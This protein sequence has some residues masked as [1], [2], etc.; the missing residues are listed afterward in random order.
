MCHSRFID[1]STLRIHRRN[2]TGESPFVCHFCGRRTKQA[3]NLASHYRHFHRNL[4][5]TS[6]II[7]F[8]A[9]VFA[10]YENDELEL[11]LR[12]DGDLCSL[13]AAGTIEYNKELE[14]QD[15]AKEME[16]QIKFEALQKEQVNA[17]FNTRK[18]KNSI[19]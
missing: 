10:R 1:G 18:G 4:E 9:R 15:R 17:K 2:H 3:Q 5:V 16:N 13:L 11:R 8:N 14:Q 6:K 12:E 7:R 19:G